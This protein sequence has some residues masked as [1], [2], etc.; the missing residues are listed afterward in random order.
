[1]AKPGVAVPALAIPADGAREDGRDQEPTEE[2]QIAHRVGLDL[3]EPRWREI[4][5]RAHDRLRLQPTCPA[6]RADERHRSREA[7]VRVGSCVPGVAAPRRTE[8]TV[9]RDPCPAAPEETN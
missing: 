6:T 2:Q 1:R 7:V 3:V 8:G 9:A 4:A 5:R